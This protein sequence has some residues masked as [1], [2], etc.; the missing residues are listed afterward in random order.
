MW[1]NA[2]WEALRNRMPLRRRPKTDSAET[3]SAQ[4]AVFIPLIQDFVDERISAQDFETRYLQLAK[5]Y[6]GLLDDRVSRAVNYLFCEVDALV[7]DERLRDPDDPH[8]IDEAT[9][10]VC[11]REALRTFLRIDGATEIDDAVESLLTASHLEDWDKRDRAAFLMAKWLP[12]PVIEQRLIEMLHDVD[13]AVQVSAIE[14]LVTHGGRSGILAVMSDFGERID[15]PDTSSIATRLRELQGCGRA[16]I[17]Q[18][19]RAILAEGAAPS[20][21]AGIRE[22]ERLFGHLR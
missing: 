9:L 1:P 3:A 10:R 18:Q 20:V 2:A 13:I 14:S 7:L 5:D 21:E 11:A 12:N 16:P 6:P 8:Q 19:A 4:S 17:L 15:D 22:V